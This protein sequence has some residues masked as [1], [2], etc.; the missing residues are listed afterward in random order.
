MTS[1]ATERCTVSGDGSVHVVELLYALTAELLDEHLYAPPDVYSLPKVMPL[2]TEDGEYLLIDNV[3]VRQA[4]G[5]APP[6]TKR[7][8]S[9][10]VP[11]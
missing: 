11:T 5:Q 4:D 9:S 3:W 1:K 6:R 2:P 8:R 10:E 7:T